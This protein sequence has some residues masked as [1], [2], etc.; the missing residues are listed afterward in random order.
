MKAGWN[1]KKQIYENTTFGDVTPVVVSPNFEMHSE[2]IRALGKYLNV[3][4]MYCMLSFY[5]A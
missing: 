2:S 1:R 5:L 4:H 3:Q